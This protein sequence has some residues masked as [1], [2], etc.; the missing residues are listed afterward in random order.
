MEQ[1]YETL[2]VEQEGH[3]R[4]VTLNRPER[5]NA[6]NW[7]MHEDL[8]EAMQDAEEDDET[9]VIILRGNGPCFSAGHDLY[10]VAEDY[11]SGKFVQRPLH[12]RR[13]APDET[14]MREISKPVI[15][16]IHGFV[17]P[18]GVIS[19]MGTDLIIA[20][21]GT[22]LSFEQ[23]RAGGAGC[24]PLIPFI[25]GEKKTKEWHLLGKA[26]SAEEAEQ[27]GLINK[28]VPPDQL[29]SQARQWATEIAAIPPQNVAANKA[30]INMVMNVLG[31]PV[32]HN[33]GHIYGSLG[34]GSGF[35]K[36]FFELATNKG[37]KAAL[38]FRDA[39]HGG[40]EASG[41][42]AGKKE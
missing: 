11:L 4:W 28:I 27:H 12:R 32:L 9:R 39:D 6:F 24:Y 42:N 10:E 16:A 15:S 19:V 20:A 26:M 25:I 34:H 23:M 30:A 29:Y 41:M 37:L 22:V 2:I 33:V 1:Q 7:Q 18:I 3:L 14:V 17:G 8:A 13:I 38:N 36:E 40:R 5:R 31:Q 21:E 35:D